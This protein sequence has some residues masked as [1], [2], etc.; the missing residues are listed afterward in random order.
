MV[1]GTTL[2]R[3]LSKGRGNMLT[4]IHHPRGDGLSAGEKILTCNQK[5]ANA[6]TGIKYLML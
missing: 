5:V 2:R 3:L 6:Y 4:R 1:P